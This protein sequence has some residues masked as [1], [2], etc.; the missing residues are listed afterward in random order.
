[1]TADALRVVAVADS[2]SYVKW[3]ASLLAAWPRVEASL[4]LLETPLLVSAAQ[5]QRAV[6]G[7][8]F[9]PAR[10]RRVPFAQ[11]AD[12]VASADADVVVLAGRGPLVRLAARELARLEPR[13]V[14]VSGLPGIGIPARAAALSYRAQC[15]LFVVH[16]RRE[17]DAF[18]ER[19]RML[20]IGMRFALTRLPF[21]DARPAAGGDDLVFAA[22]A[23]VPRER[24][25]RRRVA[26]LL[27]TAARADPG[28]RVVVKL[29]SAAGEKETHSERHRY[30][31]LLARLSPLPDNLV[32]S[33]APMAQALE[34]AQGLLTISSTAAIEAAGR[35][36][37]VIALDSFGISTP[38]LNEVFA[39]SGMLGDEAA[40]VAR[41]FRRPDPAWLRDNY[42][43]PAEQDDLDARV[44]ELV[45][46]RAAGSLPA[47]R[48]LT[49]RGGP[50]RLAWDRRRVLGRADR[51]LAGLVAVLVGTPARL[52]VLARNRLRARGWAPGAAAERA[53]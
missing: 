4:L 21:A 46:M 53:A 43:H 6:A 26:E 1:M 14:L 36:V 31:D 5:E 11:L 7:A 32:V 9:D 23:I 22:Q 28:R 29:R 8:G 2:D 16:S 15:D 47:P 52:A 37:P 45:A 40:V 13:P 33:Y 3:A 24:E 17:R 25:D 19:A 51:S 39:D 38:L 30:A 42:F 50:L 41:E 20:G 44:R 48:P 18:T 12:E 27:V 49:A 10:V 34:S 35:G